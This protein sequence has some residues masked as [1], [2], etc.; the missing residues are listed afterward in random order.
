[1][2]KWFISTEEF[3][4]WVKP[5]SKRINPSTFNILGGEPT[6]HP[7][8]CDLLILAKSYF[9]TGAH[10]AIAQNNSVCLT[11]NGSFLYKHPQIKQVL[12]ENHIR[13]YLSVHYK[14]VSDIVQKWQKE[15]VD[16][17]VYNPADEGHWHYFY[18]V[19]PEG[20]APCNDNDITSSWKHCTAKKYFQLYQ[21][22]IWKCAPVA[23][24][25]LMEKQFADQTDWQPYLKYQ[26][27]SPDATDEEII[28]FRDQEAES[29][30]NMCPRKPLMIKNERIA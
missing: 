11:T 5:W 6:L 23:Y 18:K 30:C 28:K 13:L 25:H 2:P 29:V 1:M 22:K 19:T 14:E 4:A 9:P 8:L 26:P 3:E 17:T 10:D 16:L 20:I 12:L 15:G 21:G 27:L 7:Q 24:L